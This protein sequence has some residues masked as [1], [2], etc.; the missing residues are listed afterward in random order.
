LGCVRLSE[1]EVAGTCEAVSFQ[2]LPNGTARICNF[3]IEGRTI[4]TPS[5]LG[6]GIRNT[7][8]AGEVHDV[9]EDIPMQGIQIVECRRKEFLPASE[10]G[11]I[12]ELVWKARRGRDG[13]RATLEGTE[14]EISVQPLKDLG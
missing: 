13:S 9:T 10:H 6:V 5:P 8:L 7:L 2:A 1:V 3:G 11:N 14:A 12:Y 4:Q